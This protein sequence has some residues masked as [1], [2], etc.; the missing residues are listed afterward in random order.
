MRTVAILLGTPTP[1]QSTETVIIPALK[2]VHTLFT[3]RPKT[4]DYTGAATSRVPK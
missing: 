4:E 3:D 2:T 1:Y